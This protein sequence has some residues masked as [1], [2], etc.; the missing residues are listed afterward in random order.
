MSGDDDSLTVHDV[1]VP[2]KYDEELETALAD[3]NLDDVK[4][5]LKSSSKFDNIRVKTLLLKV[6]DGLVDHIERT[7]ITKVDD[8]IN[9]YAELI[10]YLNSYKDVIVS[11]DSDLIEHNE[12]DLIE[13][14][15]RVK[16]VRKL[17]N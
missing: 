12:G 8:G 5:I 3:G 11:E 17:N 10:T 4:R 16:R 9:E 7:C 1:N 6:Q 2:Y 15:A 14:R 13:Y